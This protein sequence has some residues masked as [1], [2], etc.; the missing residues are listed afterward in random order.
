MRRIQVAA[1]GHDDRGGLGREPHFFSPRGEDVGSDQLEARLA[2]GRKATIRP[3]LAQDL[4]D[5]LVLVHPL[6]VRRAQQDL[7]EEH[8]GAA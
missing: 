7:V 6:R 5:K 4:V 8:L 3:G 1:A 2:L